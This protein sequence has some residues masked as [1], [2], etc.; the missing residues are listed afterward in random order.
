MTRL[1]PWNRLWVVAHWQ[2]ASFTCR[3]VGESGVKQ[4]RRFHLST[5]D[6]L[7]DTEKVE[8]RAVVA[9]QFS[10]SLKRSDSEQRRRDAQQTLGRPI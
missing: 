8:H 6:G 1:P 4:S 5:A 2:H 3:D 7:K 9:Y 10:H